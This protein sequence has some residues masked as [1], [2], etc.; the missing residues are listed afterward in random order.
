M[1]CSRRNVDG[2]PCRAHA[3]KGSDRCAAHLSINGTKEKLTPELTDRLVAVLRTGNYIEVAC[4]AVGL[5]PRTFRDWMARGAS[6]DRRDLI[7]RGFRER[8]EE[9]RALGEV[10][11]VREVQQA[12]RENWQA[13]AWM[14][15]RSYPER[16][17]RLSQRPQ[18]EDPAPAE[19][20]ADPFDEVDELAQR[21][22]RPT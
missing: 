5:P 12:A 3:M 7:Y 16:W 11:L 14:L 17:A 2:Q 13:A 22:S 21:R 18:A 8:V 1:R 6:G 15:E 19:K 10:A 20:P 9:A 4:R